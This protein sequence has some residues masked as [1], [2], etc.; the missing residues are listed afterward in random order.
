MTEPL[1]Y[2]DNSDERRVDDGA[3]DRGATY[4]TPVWVKVF[5]A[6]IVV[7]LVVFA[8]TLALGVRHGPGLH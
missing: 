7:V 6:V 4:S 1:P 8:I 3:D 5:G 2:P